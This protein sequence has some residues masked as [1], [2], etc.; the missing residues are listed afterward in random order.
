MSLEPR[1]LV[2]GQGE[3]CRV[4]FAEPEGCERLENL[5]DPVNRGRL[6][7]PGCRGRPP[8]G[9]DVQLTLRGSQ[10]SSHLIGLSQ[11]DTGGLGD[12]LEHLLVE[13]HDAMGLLQ[14]RLEAGVEVL[15]RTPVLTGQQKRGDHVGLDRAGTKQR[16]VDDEVLEGLRPEL[17]D[18]LALTRTLDLEAP[19]R[20]RGPDQPERPVVLEGDLRPVV[21]VDADAVDPGHLIDSV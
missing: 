21:E 3:R 17:A 18:Q 13:D 6:V 14:R 8:P 1:R 4:G 11:G 10:C 7:T 5:P 9:L 2:G 15:R 20:V 12:D 19:Q 16:D